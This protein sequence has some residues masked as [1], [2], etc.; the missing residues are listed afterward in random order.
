ML[1]EW[2]ECGGC[3]DMFQS[4]DLLKA[5]SPWL[6]DVEIL[7]CPCCGNPWGEPM[8]QI[9]DYRDGECDNHATCGCPHPTKRYVWRCFEHQPH[10]TGETHD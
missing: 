2:L 3:G 4:A 8:Y 10:K 7:G 1:T 6:E 5:P 9:C